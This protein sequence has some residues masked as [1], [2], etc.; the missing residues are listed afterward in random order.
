MTGL[1]EAFKERIEG[2]SWDSI[3]QMALHFQVDIESDDNKVRRL[4][5]EVGMIKHILHEHL[6]TPENAEKTLNAAFFVRL[7]KTITKLEKAAEK[8]RAERTGFLM[9]LKAVLHKLKRERLFVFK[10]LE[11]KDEFKRMKVD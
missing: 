11:R 8:H 2:E 4:R 5:K 7:V 6:K 3:A 1:S 9:F 10:T